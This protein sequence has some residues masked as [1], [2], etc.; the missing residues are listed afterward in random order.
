MV[1][2]LSRNHFYRNFPKTIEYINQTAGS[3]GNLKQNKYHAFDF[4]INNV[5]GNNSPPN[6]LPFL[7][8][9][10]GFE[11]RM[12][13]IDD[14]LGPNSLYSLTGE[15]GF[16]T[17]IATEFCHRYFSWYMGETVN[18]DHIAASFWCAAKKFSG[19]WDIA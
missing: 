18:V 3:E 13:A 7:T 10:I 17:F 12:D 2:S 14:F 15:M 11:T 16:V 4:K 5:M 6:L 1:D 8:G 9:K 19:Y